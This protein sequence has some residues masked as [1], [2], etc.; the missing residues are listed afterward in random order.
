M[1]DDP[2][3]VKNFYSDLVDW[4]A[5]TVQDPPGMLFLLDSAL[6]TYEHS[7]YPC[8]DPGPIV[9]KI[10]RFIDALIDDPEAAGATR[11][12]WDHNRA[13]RYARPH[14]LHH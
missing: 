6:D 7:R 14:K 10:H 3:I 11:L 9:R 1:D 8:P 2:D 5:G 13:P 12:R 4:G